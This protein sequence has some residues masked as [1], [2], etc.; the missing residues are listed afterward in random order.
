MERMRALSAQRPLVKRSLQGSLADGLGHSSAPC[1]GRGCHMASG[2]PGRRFTHSA[3]VSDGLGSSALA[4]AT[5]AATKASH[6]LGRSQQA[7]EGRSRRGRS[8]KPRGHYKSCRA[9]AADTCG[10]KVACRART[11]LS[12]R[13]RPRRER[14]QSEQ[15][16]QQ[17][18]TKKTYA[19]AAVTRMSNL[20]CAKGARSNWR[21]RAW[22]TSTESS[23]IQRMPNSS[24]FNSDQRRPAAAYINVGGAWSAARAAGGV[25]WEFA[26]H[27]CG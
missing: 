10:R 20:D 22:A 15:R 16:P 6:A 21:Q 25:G 27:L 3:E 7:P 18:A 9:K 24:P 8:W 1:A 23:Q 14:L 26:A 12:P 17:P 5:R 19:K 4:T 13:C 11:D 2:G